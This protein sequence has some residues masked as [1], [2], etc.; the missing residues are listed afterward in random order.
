[1]RNLFITIVIGL[2]ICVFIIC[3]FSGR[4]N[5]YTY[6]KRNSLNVSSFSERYRRPDSVKIDSNYILKVFKGDTVTVINLNF[7]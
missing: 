7:K 4:I 1:M 5:D 3:L 6:V 2:S